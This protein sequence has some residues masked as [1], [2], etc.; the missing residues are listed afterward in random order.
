MLVITANEDNDQDAAVDASVDGSVDAAV[1]LQPVVQ[2]VVQRGFNVLVE[3][4]PVVQP[5]VHRGFN[6]CMQFSVP[7]VRGSVLVFLAAPSIAAFTAAI[8]PACAGMMGT[9]DV[10]DWAERFRKGVA[11]RIALRGGAAGKTVL[12]GDADLV[13]D[14]E[15]VEA[16]E[17]F[18]GDRREHGGVSTRG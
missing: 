10:V 14:F 18:V 2:P 5:V 16:M 6:V 4:Q 9:D 8:A 7:Y 12:Q 11:V 1:E 15:M 3:L 13:R 17:A